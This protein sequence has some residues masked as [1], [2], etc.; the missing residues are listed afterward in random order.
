M[1]REKITKFSIQ[2]LKESSLKKSCGVRKPAITFF[3]SHALLVQE[4]SISKVPLQEKAKLQV[5]I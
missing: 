1:S 5:K 4:K 3:D 2:A